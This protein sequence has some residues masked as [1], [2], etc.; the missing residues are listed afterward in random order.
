M[1][2]CKINITPKSTTWERSMDL[3]ALI[4]EIFGKRIAE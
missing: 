1:Y 2:N 3:G 4:L